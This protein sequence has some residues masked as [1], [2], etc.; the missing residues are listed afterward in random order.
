M[1]SARIKKTV[2]GAGIAAA[3]VVA[4]GGAAS[5]ST[6]SG[7]VTICARGDY[8]SGIRVNSSTYIWAEPGKCAS[9]SAAHT[10]V[11]VYAAFWDGV[12]LTLNESS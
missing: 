2:A 1:L 7:T 6:A 10:T 4:G 5:A 8:T 12:N 11:T 3:L 9:S